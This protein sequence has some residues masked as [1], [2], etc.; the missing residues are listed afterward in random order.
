[1]LRNVF[2]LVVL[3]LS[4]WVAIASCTMPV[5]VACGGAPWLVL[6]GR[7]IVG[8]GVRLLTVYVGSCPYVRLLCGTHAAEAAPTLLYVG[9]ILVLFVS[10]LYTGVRA[11]H[12]T[13]CVLAMGNAYGPVRA[14][15]MAAT[16]LMFGAVDGLFL[17]CVVCG[18][19]LCLTCALAL[20]KAQPP[21]EEQEAAAAEAP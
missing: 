12:S 20:R 8:V 6:L 5:F 11:L 1:M 10:E 14:P 4:A 3:L 13:P 9:L 21:Q 17:T 15:L 16:L 7:I 18:G 19:L 2:S